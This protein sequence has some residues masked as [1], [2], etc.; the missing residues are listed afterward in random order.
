VIA[1]SDSTEFRRL[2]AGLAHDIVTAHIHWKLRNDL[3]AAMDA[4]PFVRHQSTTFWNLTLEAHGQVAVMALCRAFDQERSSLHLLSWLRTIE[5]NL[6]LFEVD[7]FKQRL[8]TN[9]FVNSL[10][11]G[12]SPPE[13]GQ[14]SA[15]I[16]SCMGTDPF[17][18]TLVSLR[19]VA[20]AH[21]GATV[22]VRGEGIGANAQL[23]VDQFEVLLE[24]AKA[25]LNRY[26][27][28]FAAESYSTST[29][30]RDDY[31]ALFE[32]VTER[33]ER[34]RR[35][36]HEDLRKFSSTT[37]HLAALLAER[38]TL[39]TR[40]TAL[41]TEIANAREALRI[42][43]LKQQQ[44]EAPAPSAIERS[45]ERLAQVKQWVEAGESAKDI[46][47]RLT[48]SVEWARVL[49]RQAKALRSG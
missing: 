17:V 40:R 7:Q 14:L 21:R 47:E 27:Q 38:A 32:G 12:V 41:T 11:E 48:A 22:A 19:G 24:R 25:I 6:W 15:D 26:S 36:T 18:K 34:L 2:V 13:A 44:A 42:D 20:I 43:R 46:A 45:H 16:A 49:M 9:P 31:Q 37:N 1:V 8:A 3:F 5:D 30:G 28:L 10:A 33:V 23:T 39:D 4:Y 29:I 35:Q